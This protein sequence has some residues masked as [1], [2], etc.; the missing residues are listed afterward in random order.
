VKLHFLIALKLYRERHSGIWD[1]ELHFCW[2]TDQSKPTIS[3]EIRSWLAL[4][5]NGNAKS[6]SIQKSPGDCIHN[7][8][9][10]NAI[11]IRQIVKFY[12][13]PFTHNIE[14]AKTF[15]EGITFRRYLIFLR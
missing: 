4:T 11:L 10:H 5:K 8:R 6:R 13:S 15:T 9:F 1:I 7:S 14:L 12:T 2:L 3:V